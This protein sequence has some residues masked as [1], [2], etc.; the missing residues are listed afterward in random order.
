[1]EEQLLNSYI[2]FGKLYGHAEHISAYALMRIFS[3]E[4]RPVAI[5]VGSDDQVRLWLNGKLIH[6]NMQLRSP[7]PDSDATPATLSAGWNTLLA[8]VINATGQHAL[9]LRLSDAPADLL[10]AHDAAKN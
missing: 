4:Q 9:Y 5:L 10:R 1:M 2:N 7:A 3:P 8:R 6:E